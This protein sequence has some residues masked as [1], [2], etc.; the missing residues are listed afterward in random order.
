MSRR[1][2]RPAGAAAL[3]LGA[4]LLVATDAAGAAT[5]TIVNVDSPGEGFNDLTPVAAVAGNAGT[6]RGQQRLNVFAAAAAYWANRLA[7]PVP[8]IVQASMDSLTCSPSSAVLGSAGVVAAVSDFPNAPRAD[9]WYP[10]ALANALAGTDLAPANRD[11]AAQFN[12]RL[13]DDPTCLTTH[14]WWYG[15]GAPAPAGTLSFYDVVW[16]EL[17]HGLG[18]LTFVHPVTGSRFLDQDDIYM[19]LLEDHST[20][21]TWPQMSDA[22]RAVSAKDNGDLH[23]IGAQAVAAGAALAAGRHP[24]GHLRIYAPST[25]SPGSSIA[26]WDTVLVPD[27]LMEPFAV[28]APADAVTTALLHD[29]GWATQSATACVA[30]ATTACLQNGRFEVRVQFQTD[31]A[32]GSAAVQLFN[33]QRAENAE[34]A[35][36]T[37]FSATNF[38]MGVKVLFAC[39]LTS[40][41]WVFASGLTNQGWTV[42]VRDTQTGA[43]R[44]YSNVVGHLSTTFADNSAFDCP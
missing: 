41:W 9:T 43:Q 1:R 28:A 14:D 5:L 12:R 10:V 21:K 37:F 30:D 8:V 2:R 39:P 29:L 40:T 38:E 16:H 31:T 23:W 42:T 20:G 19:T 25:P 22:E 4:L 7:S 13:D 17:A 32:S 27:E 15:I 35:F 36:F 3:L 33:G 34:S 24:G 6:T 26:H 11:V 44:T 18:F